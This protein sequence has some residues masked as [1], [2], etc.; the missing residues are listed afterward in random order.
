MRLHEAI[1]TA[2]ADMFSKPLLF[3]EFDKRDKEAQEAISKLKL[4]KLD[5]KKDKSMKHL[6]KLMFYKSRMF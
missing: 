5:K 1:A 3:A 6:E 4:M 2:N